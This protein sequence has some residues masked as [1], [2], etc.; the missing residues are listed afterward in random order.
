MIRLVT[1]KGKKCKYKTD[2]H[3][4]AQNTD[5]SSQ[6]TQSNTQFLSWYTQ[7]HGINNIFVLL[8]HHREILK[9]TETNNN[10]KK[11]DKNLMLVSKGSA[12]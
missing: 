2:K 1:S 9:F 3:E 6:K 8:H 5:V 7:S 4:L 10:N 11:N 12:F